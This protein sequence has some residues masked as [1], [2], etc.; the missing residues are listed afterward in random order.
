MELYESWLFFQ[1]E[2]VQTR[3]RKAEWVIQGVNEELDAELAMQVAADLYGVPVHE[4]RGKSRKPL[5]VLARKMAIR[6]MIDFTKFSLDK[7]GKMMGGRDHSTISFNRD[8]LKDWMDTDEVI[9][10]DY[11]KLK[12]IFINKKEAIK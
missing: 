4:I 9:R 5:I 7:I 8:S 12:K 3:L 6:L 10:T 11:L 2:P 1:S